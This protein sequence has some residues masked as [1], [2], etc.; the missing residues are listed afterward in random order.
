M[1][2]A[3]KAGEIRYQELSSPDSSVRAIT[4]AVP[5]N[6]DDLTAQS[7]F[8]HACSDVRMMMLHTDA[9]QRQLHRKLRA[10]VVWMQVVRYCLRRH[11]K[12]PLHALECLLQELHRLQ[13]FEV[14]DMLTQQPGT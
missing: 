2:E 9:F 1:C 14:A 8:R 7:V 10:E 3:F 13:V 4:S 5:G 11:M 6:A 12:E